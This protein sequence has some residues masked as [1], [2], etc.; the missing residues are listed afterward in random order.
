M[1]PAR[2]DV[3]A[4]LPRLASGKYDLAALAAPAA[5]PARALGAAGA[6]EGV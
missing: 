4:E 3:R 2:V 1:Q 6:E 5:P